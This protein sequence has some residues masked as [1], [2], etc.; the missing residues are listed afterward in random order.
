M[1][2]F[3][4]VPPLVVPP[5]LENSG[6]VAHAL[7]RAAQFSSSVVRRSACPLV[8]TLVLALTVFV[9]CASA[10][11]LSIVSGDGQVAAQNFQFPSP[12]VVVAKDGSGRPVANVPVN[13]SISGPGNLVM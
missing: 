8:S 6:D 12:L 7:V 5:F 1:G 9:A 2:P 10:Q 11:S 4:V 13:W 3:H